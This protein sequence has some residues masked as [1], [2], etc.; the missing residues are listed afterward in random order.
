M[1]KAKRR[2]Y[3]LARVN[4]HEALAVLGSIQTFTDGPFELI[5]MTDRDGD[6]RV[7]AIYRTNFDGTFSHVGGD[8]SLGDL[9]VDPFRSTGGAGEG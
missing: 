7:T 9:L 4:D 2:I 6:V 5:A 3:G 1:H 8:N